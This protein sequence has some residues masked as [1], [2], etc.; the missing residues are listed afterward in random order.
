MIASVQRRLVAAG[1]ALASCLALAFPAEARARVYL[2][3]GLLDVSTGLDDLAVKLKKAGYA[4]TVTSYTAEGQLAETA[5]RNYKSGAGCPVVIIGHSLGADAAL[6]MASDLKQ[7]SIPVAL[8]IA[9]SPASIKSLPSNV[10]KVVNYYQS[11]SAWNNPY[12]RSGGFHGSL[13]NVNLA[14][15]GN[16]DHFNIEKQ[17]RLH[18]EVIGM[19]ASAGG[20]CGA[21][22][23]P[24]AEAV[25]TAATK[26]AN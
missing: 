23:K 2:M 15:D 19:V 4:S 24:K 13:R 16:V 7:K 1:I 6:Q 14:K 26:A 18:R 22:A 11:N 8:I 25:D 20:A 9:F 12:S 17:A 10:A 21:A 5:A 3:R